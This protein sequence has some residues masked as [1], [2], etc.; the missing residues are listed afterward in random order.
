MPAAH[1]GIGGAGNV[2]PSS[3]PELITARHVIGI[4]MDVEYQTLQTI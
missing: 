4:K 1:I 3:P 2:R